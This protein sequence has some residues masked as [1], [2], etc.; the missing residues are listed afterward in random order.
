[1]SLATLIIQIDQSGMTIAL[2]SLQRGLGATTAQLQWVVDAYS[3]ALAAVVL[4]AGALS[5]RLGRKRVFLA[6][7]A[8]FAVASFAGALATDVDVVV[9]ARA[10]LGI[11]AAMFMPG[12]LSILT[13]V[14]SEETRAQAIGIWGGATSLGIVIGPV[15]GG[16]LLQSFD[17]HAIFVTNVVVALVVFAFAVALVPE[18]RDPHPPALDPAGALLSALGLLGLTYGIIAL[19]D[20]DAVKVEGIVTLAGGAV[21]MTLFLLRARRHPEGMFDMTIVRTSTFRGAALAAAGMMFV[22]NGLLLVLTQQ[23]Q[24]AQGYSPLLTGV[25]IMPMAASAIVS[26]LTAPILAARTSPRVSMTLGLGLLALAAIAYGLAQPITGYLPILTLLVLMGLGVG[27]I[28]AVSNDV[29]MSSGPRHRSG[30][31]SSMN[32][33]VQEVGAALGIAV[34]GAVLSGGYLTSLHHA[35]P[36]AP[37]SSLFAALAATANDRQRA[38]LARAAFADGSRL[39]AL[40]AGGIGAVFALTIAIVLRPSSLAARGGDLLPN[41]EETNGLARHR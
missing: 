29:L 18:S 9:A 11:G 41:R 27:F 12:T 33:T 7:V 4:T 1:M 16:T 32:D 26:S 25:A 13:Q 34:I 37:S 10:G 24:L 5:D 15:L 31:I 40:V 35:T 19:S 36:G 39:A 2:P 17:W 28:A 8:L 3:L 14:F 30:L 6:G 20:S 22:M 23:V 38:D 21:L